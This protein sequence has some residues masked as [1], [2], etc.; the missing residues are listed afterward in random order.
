MREE[1]SPQPRSEAAPS[2]GDGYK[3]WERILEFLKRKD[4]SLLTAQLAERYDGHLDQKSGVL[5]ML[6]VDSEEARDQ[7]SVEEAVSRLLSYI[8]LPVK[9][10]DDEIE[11]FQEW[12]DR[13]IEEYINNDPEEAISALFKNIDTRSIKGIEVIK[14]LSNRFDLAKRHV[15]L[16]AQSSQFPQWYDLLNQRIVLA[17]RTSAHRLKVDLQ[18]MSAHNEDLYFPYTFAKAFAHDALTSTASEEADPDRDV[19]FKLTGDIYAA[20]TFDKK[21][22]Y[23]ASPQLSHEVDALL[24]EGWEPPSEKNNHTSPDLVGRII[25][26]DYMSLEKYLAQEIGVTHVEQTLLNDFVTLVHSGVRKLIEQD[27]DVRL[28]DL[29]VREQI[30]FLNY[31]KRVTLGGFETF[32][33]FV[34]KYGIDGMRTF[35]ATEFGEN[36]PDVILGIAY[37]DA[38]SDQQAES[39]FAKYAEII[40][41]LDDAEHRLREQYPDNTEVVS[42]ALLNVRKRSR[43]L[44]VRAHNAQNPEQFMASLERLNLG[45]QLFTGLFDALVSERGIRNIAEMPDVH[46]DVFSSQEVRERNLLPQLKEMYRSNYVSTYGEE[47]VVALIERLDAKV[48]DASTQC[49]I[50]RHGETILG[51]MAVVDHGEYV[52]VSALNVDQPVRTTKAGLVMLGVVD[53]YAREGRLVKADAPL[54]NAQAY[55]NARGFVGTGVT[56]LAGVPL[57]LIE[58]NDAVQYPPE[59]AI[60]KT[61]ADVRTIP[62]A[63]ENDTYVITHMTQKEGE[64]TLRLARRDSATPAALAPTTLGTG[65]DA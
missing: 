48:N 3:E 53:Q 25:F 24:K 52:E 64:I 17:F 5:L 47:F 61:I 14:F 43:D 55:I 13:G 9:G 44:L 6:G 20:F 15:E 63:L 19:P 22:I 16:G 34:S 4:Q 54:D 33:D 10:Y 62:D 29:T 26:N 30:Y 2:P 36:A 58:R 31:L 7:L 56:E 39:I 18:H 23:I 1:I 27:L 65:N 46:I 49:V 57:V 59:N 11:A 8:T 41:G 60:T 38:Y 37:S 12:A 40:N 32:K 51:F 21:N 50:L 45:N 28:A 35:L 42:K